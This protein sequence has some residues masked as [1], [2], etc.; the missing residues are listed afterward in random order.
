M[1]ISKIQSALIALAQDKTLGLFERTRAAIILAEISLGTIIVNPKN[2]KLML[3][4][5]R[6]SVR[7]IT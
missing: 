4:A 5:S 6:K 2:G 7:T 3:D 1:P